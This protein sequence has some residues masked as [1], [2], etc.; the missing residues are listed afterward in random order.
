M[1]AHGPEQLRF[2]PP[3]KTKQNNSLATYVLQ[4]ALALA[5]ILAI[6]GSFASTFQAAPLARSRVAPAHP[7][8][9]E[10]PPLPITPEACA[11]SYTLAIAGRKFVSAVEDIGNHCDDCGTLI[12]LPFPVALYD[13]TFTTASAG[14]NGHLTFG[15]PYNGSAI[16]CEAFGNSSATYVLAPYWADQCTDACGTTACT[17]CGIF[18][19]TT[20]STPN[21]VFYIEFRTQYQSQTTSLV[22]YEIALFE[23]G[24]PPFQ[25]IYGNLPVAP[26]TNTSQL[27]I[28]VKR[29]GANFTQYACDATGG[30]NPP[31]NLRRRGRGQKRR[32]LVASVVPCASPSPTATPTGTPSSTPTATATATATGTPTPTPC[33]SGLIQNGGFETGAFPPWIILDQHATPVVTDMQAHSGTFS[34]FIGDPPDGFCGFMDNEANGDS[35]LY[36]QFTVPP[37]GTSALSFWHWDCTQDTIDF[38]W[39]DAYITDVNGNILQ[40]IFHQCLD[41]EDWVNTTVD[42]T[43]FAGQTVRV[44]FLVHEDN[45]GDLTGMFI[46]DVQLLVPCG[47]PTPTPTGSP[48]PTATLTP[49]ATPTG[50]ASA[51]PTATATP[52]GTPSATPT[53]T[54]TASGTP[55]ATPTGTGTPPNARQT[56]TPRPVPTV[57]ARP[58]PPPHLT[59]VPTPSSP[60]PTAVPRP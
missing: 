38:D 54:A 1:S 39:Q 22:D 6:G 53:G 60:R 19:T 4:I 59:P 3:M 26:G 58:I 21:R 20:G 47:T 11:S 40:T 52:T 17:D 29:D 51:T 45:F 49:T 41:T 44:K 37:V 48:T 2:T 30:H 23:N 50:T 34:G 7:P 28:G 14:S 36:Q 32:A 15:T 12:N 55:S 42:T 57:V 5:I 35:S 9:S 18:T 25:F 8:S 27:L 33:D 46:D 13:R 10:S 31:N 24:N 56:P 43:P 16:T